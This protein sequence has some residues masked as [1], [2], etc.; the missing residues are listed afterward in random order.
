MEAYT[1]PELA[2]QMGWSKD[3]VYRLIHRKHNPLPAHVEPDGDGDGSPCYRVID[4]EFLIWYSQYIIDPRESNEYFD[5]YRKSM[6]Q[7]GQRVPKVV[8]LQL[9]KGG[10]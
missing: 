4:I 8:D 6:A 2:R 5:Y 1:V 7:L 9:I 10:G 3:K